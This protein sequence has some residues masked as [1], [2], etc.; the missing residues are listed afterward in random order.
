M[1]CA[2]GMSPAMIPMISELRAGRASWPVVCSGARRLPETATHTDYTVNIFP[3]LLRPRRGVLP[4]YKNQ[5]G[6]QSGPDTPHVAP[7]NSAI[8]GIKDDAM[9]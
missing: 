7:D 3:A 2:A 4:Q 5:D 8:G 6:P 9:I 1:N